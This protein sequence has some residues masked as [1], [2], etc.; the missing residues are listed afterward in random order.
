VGGVNNHNNRERAGS[1]TPFPPRGPHLCDW[2]LSALHTFLTDCMTSCSC[3]WLDECHSRLKN[4]DVREVADVDADRVFRGSFILALYEQHLGPL[5][6]VPYADDLASRLA[7]MFAQ[8]I[9]RMLLAW[10]G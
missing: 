1:L 10:G 2:N 6:F 7:D 4:A 5:M 8:P 3:P 9:T